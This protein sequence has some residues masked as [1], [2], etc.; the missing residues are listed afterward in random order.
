MRR[1]YLPPAEVQALIDAR[2]GGAAAAEERADP[3][4]TEEGTS[5]AGGLSSPSR[6]EYAVNR[7]FRGGVVDADLLARV[8]RACSVVHGGDFDQAGLPHQVQAVAEVYNVLLSFASHLPGG[9][10]SLRQLD[11]E[12]L[13]AQLRVLLQM[14]ALK[15][16]RPA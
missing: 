14:G 7:A 12:A 8:A 11:Q 16:W 5:A 10:E 1:D 13:V 4:V 3:E 2:K 9:P 15:P 6:P